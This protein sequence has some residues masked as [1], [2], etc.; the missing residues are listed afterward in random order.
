MPQLDFTTYVS[1]WAWLAITFVLFYAAMAKLAL[2]RVAAVLD[3]RERRISHDLAEAERLRAETEA[4]IAA[5]EA[6][7]NE[8]RAKAQA[9]AEETRHRIAAESA[10]RRVALDAELAR[11]VKDAEA[12]ILAARETASREVSGIASDLAQALIKQLA[13]ID[14]SQATVQAA[15]SDARTRRAA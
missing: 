4:A 10:A 8:A 3:E 15:L 6:A 7:L 11:S 13:G 12:R 9:L 2:P 1:Q 5:Y 14:A